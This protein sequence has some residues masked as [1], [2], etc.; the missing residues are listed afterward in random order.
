MATYFVAPLL[1]VG[2]GFSFLNLETPLL[3]KAVHHPRR[4]GR[5]SPS[6]KVDLPEEARADAHVDRSGS[7]L[8]GAGSMFVPTSFRSRDGVFDLLVFF[9]GNVDLVAQSAAAAKLEAIVLVVNIGTGSGA[10]ES[11]YF[12]PAIFQRELDRV[13][14][15]ATS[16]GLVGARL[17]RLALGAWSAGYGA[18]LRIL[19][20]D[21]IRSR[22]SA[23]LLADALHSNLKDVHKRTVDME[24][25]AP[26][27]RFAEQAAHGDK[28]FVMTHSEVNEFR[29]A[30]TTET[31]TALIDAVGANRF[32][33]TDWPQRPTFSLARRVMSQETWLEQ[34]SEAHKGN[35]RVRGY[36]GFRE[37]DHIAHL[38]QISTTLFAELVAYWSPLKTSQGR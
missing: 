11:H 37:N 6:R 36:R 23:V 21:S 28:L 30:T 2:A 38:A 12:I 9:H 29:Y 27:V 13:V 26:F 34:C 19:T 32:R 14:E 31:S 7:S 35:F 18:I 1:M 5:Q 25:I 8:V 16:R 20:H 10:Y 17:G 33:T 15:V 22:T 3:R 24:R 4:S